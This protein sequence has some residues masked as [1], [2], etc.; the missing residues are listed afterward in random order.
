MSEPVRE[1]I[2]LDLSFKMDNRRCFCMT[3]KTG[4][5]YMDIS[6]SATP[7]ASNL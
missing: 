4:Q 3:V 7:D 5:A 1:K 2:I 6:Y